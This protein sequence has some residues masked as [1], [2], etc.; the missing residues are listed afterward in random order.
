MPRFLAWVQPNT[1][2]VP[3]EPCVGDRGASSV[4]Q[5]N[6][7][8]SRAA[9]RAPARRDLCGP[10]M[11]VGLVWLGLDFHLASE[12]R[13]RRAGR[14]ADLPQPRPR[15]RGASLALP[16]GRRP[17]AADPARQLRE[18]PRCVRFHRLPEDHAR[19]RSSGHAGRH[20]RAQRRRPDAQRRTGAPAR[21]RQRSART[22]GIWPRPASTSSS[23]ASRWSA[24]EP[25][26]SACI[27][28]ARCANR[29][30]RSTASSRH[31]S[32]RSTSPSSISRSISGATAYVS[33]VGLG[34]HRARRRRIAGEPDRREPHG[35]AVVQAARIGAVRLVLRRRRARRR[36]S[37]PEGLSRR[38]RTFP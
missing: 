25:R 7:I 15:L 29:M 20:H 36:R 5:T 8:G 19:F 30:A 16:E 27:S 12:R 9:S 14:G 3:I 24:A 10:A 1:N 4:E 31:R 6:K 37:A 28:R 23:S 35:L 11:I 33:V 2:R 18:Q 13:A 38:S 22:S 34:R 32:I 17:H 21:Q 26:S